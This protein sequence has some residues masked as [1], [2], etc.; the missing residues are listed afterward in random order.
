[1][2]NIFISACCS[3]GQQK[4]GVEHGPRYLEN[5]CD[6]VFDH[7][8]SPREF[9]KFTGYQKLYDIVKQNMSKFQ[10]IVGGD[11][12]LA[13]GS[14]GAV[15][16]YYNSIDKKLFVIW[17]DAHADINTYESS[18][19]N[20][21]HGMP[22]AFLMKLCDQTLVDL[23][24]KLLPSQI[25][26]IGLRS[27]DPPEQLFLD[28]LGIQY[29]TMQDVKAKGIS[30]IMEEIKLITESND[31]HVSLDIDG[32]DPTYCPSTG[33]VVNDGLSIDNVTDIIDSLNNTIV[34][35]DIVE[36]NPFETTYIDAEITATTIKKL[37]KCINE[38]KKIVHE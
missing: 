31:V 25:I 18:E 26:Y 4:Y 8:I 10:I 30:K 21:I 35:C 3:A 16:D 17:I 12:S 36:F 23:K 14:V 11:H 6:I 2:D 38:N 15:V 28:E 33:V 29:Y 34:S 7:T 20:N 19:S 22:V 37:I 13:V 32:I 24:S 27:V 5:N 9:Y 1:M